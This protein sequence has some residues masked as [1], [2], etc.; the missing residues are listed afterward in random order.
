M[1]GVCVSL[2]LSLAPAY[3]CRCMYVSSEVTQERYHAHFTDLHDLRSRICVMCP[4]N[5]LHPSKDG[6]TSVHRPAGYKG[7]CQKSVDF[8]HPLLTVVAACGVPLLYAAAAPLH[9]RSSLATLVSSEPDLNAESMSGL[10]VFVAREVYVVD[11]VWL[12]W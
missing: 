3:T 7:V 2:S 9:V 10:V 1:C 11:I 5:A 4:K 8:L 12:P 6:H